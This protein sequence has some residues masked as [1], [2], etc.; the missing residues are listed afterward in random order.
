MAYTERAKSKIAPQLSESTQGT[1]A[2]HIH[3][4]FFEVRRHQLLSAM[5]DRHHLNADHILKIYKHATKKTHF[6]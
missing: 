4:E 6:Y 1:I 3:V 5:N 2:E